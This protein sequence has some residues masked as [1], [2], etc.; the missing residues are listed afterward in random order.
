M[1]AEPGY[2]RLLLAA[3]ESLHARPAAER[4]MVTL[5]GFAWERLKR[6]HKKMR[7]L[8]LAA[9][10]DD[11]ASLHALRIGVKR[12]R[13]ALEFFS[14]L[15]RD[16]ASFGVLKQLTSL[17]DTLG[18]LNDLANA[19]AVLMD[20]AGDDPRLREAVTLIGGWHGPR[21]A[22]LLERISAELV[23]LGRLRLP[24][25]APRVTSLQQE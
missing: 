3:L 17:Q 22:G 7:R 14:P 16:A 4:T 1:L 18:Q 25:L 23:R 8:A 2:G 15:T 9:R 19:G 5:T 24:R 20:C 11:P 10:I 6:L 13:Y 21:Y 12:L